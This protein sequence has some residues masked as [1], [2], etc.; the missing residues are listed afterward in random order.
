MTVKYKLHGNVWIESEPRNWVLKERFN[1]KGKEPYVENLGYY[2]TVASAYRGY[3]EQFGTRAK[4]HAEL[5]ELCDH[6]QFI[7]DRECEAAVDALVDA[8]KFLQNEL[9]SGNNSPKMLEYLENK[10]SKL[11]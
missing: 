5:E 10:I 7:M 2:P 6:V 8:K 4:S 3:F 9:D 11:K 1:P